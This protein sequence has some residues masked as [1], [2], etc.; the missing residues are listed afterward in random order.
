MFYT[1]AG[2]CWSYGDLHVVFLRRG[3]LANAPTPGHGRDR[4][5]SRAGAAAVS[6]TGGSDGAGPKASSSAGWPM[7]LRRVSHNPV[8]AAT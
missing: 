6:G 2:P 4:A 5:F 3:G 7:I 8:Q 1:G